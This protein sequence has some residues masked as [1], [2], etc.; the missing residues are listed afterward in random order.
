MYA[1]IEDSGTLFKVAS[2]DV[3]VFYRAAAGD[4]QVWP[5]AIC[6][7]RGLRGGGEGQRALGTPVVCGGGGRAEVRGAG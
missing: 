6:F 1:V 5:Q 7:D 3:I 4:G 2:G